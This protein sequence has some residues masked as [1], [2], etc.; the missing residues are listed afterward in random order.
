MGEGG[1]S[2]KHE[3]VQ[4]QFAAT[5]R[6]S[7][8]PQGLRVCKLTSVRRIFR[9]GLVAVTEHLAFEVLGEIGDGGGGGDVETVMMF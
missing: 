5:K 9:T 2:R 8:F 4:I 1:D 3:W 6:R 7:D